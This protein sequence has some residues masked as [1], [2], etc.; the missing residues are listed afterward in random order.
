MAFTAAAYHP[1][2]LLRYIIYGND[3]VLRK[4][5]LNPLPSRIGSSGWFVSEHHQQI[6]IYVFDLCIEN[7]LGRIPQES[8]SDR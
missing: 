8:G 4:S 1:S 6:A 7:L 2:S 3:L 5:Q